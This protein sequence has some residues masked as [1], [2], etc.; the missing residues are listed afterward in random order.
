MADP[1][2]RYECA[3]AL[4]K[5]HISDK[6]VLKHCTATQYKAVYIAQMVSM[7]LPIDMALVGVGALLHDIGRAQ[8]HDV[9]HGVIGGQILLKEG[10]SKQVIRVAERHVLGG[11]TAREASLIGLPRRSFLPVTWEEK[12]VC[13]AD[14]L[15]RYFWGGIDV[16]LNWLSKVQKRCD[17]LR[18]RYGKDEPFQESMRRVE[19]Y[20]RSLIQLVNESNVQNYD[21]MLGS[22][23]E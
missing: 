2:P 18:H 3:L 21:K 4:L 14:K 6:Q 19:Q 9:T 17:R 13:V 12:I 15:G 5:H 11:F 16:P 8:V 23:G 10:Y 22:K 7:H 20:T 1:L